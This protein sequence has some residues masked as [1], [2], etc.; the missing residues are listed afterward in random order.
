MCRWKMTSTIAYDKPVENLIDA[1]SATGHVTHRSYTKKSVTL[2]HNGGRLSHQGVLTVWKT[3]PASAHFDVDAYGRVA[4][5][6]KTL[7]YA[8]AVANTEGNMETI[9][10]ELCNLTLSPN[11][12]VADVTW[13]EGA[14]LA[15][16][17]FAHV[18][19]TRP[20]S[21]TLHYHHYW[22]STSCA[23]PFMDKIYDK[24]LA[25]AQAAYD[26]FRVNPTRPP[27]HHL[28]EVQQ[29][30][31]ALEVADDNHWGPATDARALML[32]TASRAH[33]GF[34]HNTAGQFDV[35]AVQ[36]VIDTTPDGAWGPNSQKALVAWVK[37]TQ[38]ILGVAS[39]GRWGPGTDGAYLELRKR[40]L[41]H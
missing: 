35:R 37:E 39:D 14:R 15:G 18:I 26:H 24:V 4:Q 31:R 40:S 29:I 36:N 41:G 38:H 7:E 28:T 2:H 34:P 32:R 21:K 33:V 9:S 30:Q 5:Y 11:W 22:Y 6:V 13:E 10:I 1:L 3:R 12:E 17:L 23:G 27:V 19:G 16:W 8:W 25:A 20:T